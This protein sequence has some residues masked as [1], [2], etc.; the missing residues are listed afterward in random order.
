[1]RNNDSFPKKPTLQFLYFPFYPLLIPAFFLLHGYARF[2]DLIPLSDLCI[3]YLVSGSIIT[4]ALLLCRRYLKS[5]R[6]AAIVIGVCSILYFFFGDIQLAI[7]GIPA[8]SGLGKYSSL[9][10]IFLI[11]I[12]LIAVSLKRSKGNFVRL[13][14]YLNVVFVIFCLFDLI[15]IVSVFTARKKESKTEISSD[16][17]HCHSCVTPDIYLVI[18]DEYAGVKSLK[19]NFNFDNSAFAGFFKSRGFFVPESTHSNYS[20]TAISMASLFTMN[21]VLWAVKRNKL[22]A[23]DHARAEQMMDTS[24]VTRILKDYHYSF[25]NYSIFNLASQASRFD[26]GFLPTQLKL[27]TAQTFATK[28]TKD[29]FGSIQAGLGARFRWAEE[30]HENAFRNGNQRLMDLTLSSTSNKSQKPKFVYTHLLMPHTP[31]VFDSL[32][33]Q[34]RNKAFKDLR[35]GEEDSL[36]LSYLVYTNKIIIT[37]VD[38]LMTAT[39]NKAVVMVMSDHGYRKHAPYEIGK[40]NDNFSAVFIPGG[41]YHL[42]YDSVSNVNQFRLLFNTMFRARLPLLTDKSYF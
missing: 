11:L 5:V 31:Y 40:V 29:V 26:P 27:I 32:G 39:K 1:M 3:Y 38:S 28:F 15:V 37:F 42:Y 41:D 20:A 36:Y 13:T 19:S 14:S 17:R 33:H 18:L 4:V 9:I 8:L 23:E 6:K 21:K 10:I 7:L 35:K 34:V 2:L 12:S 16:V 30:Y 24:M 22:I 25:Y